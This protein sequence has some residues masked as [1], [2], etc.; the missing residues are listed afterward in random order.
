MRDEQGNKKWKK[1]KKKKR[2]GNHN[3]SVN[4]KWTHL[5]VMGGTTLNL[6]NCWVPT[7]WTNFSNPPGKRNRNNRLA[8]GWFRRKFQTKMD[9]EKT[10]EEPAVIAQK[11]VKKICHKTEDKYEGRQETSKENVNIAKFWLRRLLPKFTKSLILLLVNL[12]YQQIKISPM[13]CWCKCK[14]TYFYYNN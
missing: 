6:P 7:W 5:D 11:K 1:A 3:F 8:T 13:L 2:E 10:L 9:I 4:Q 12:R 14:W